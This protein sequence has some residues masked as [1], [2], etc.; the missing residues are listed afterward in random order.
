MK[1]FGRSGGYYIFWTGFLYFCVGLYSMFVE[2]IVPV[3]IAQVCWIAVLSLP[4][5]IPPFGRWLNMDIT[6]DNKLFKSDSTPTNV[7]PF[8]TERNLPEPKLVPPM[9][10]VEPPKVEPKVFYRIGSTDQ[11]RVAFSMGG[12]E[13]TMN[14]VGCQQMID[15][16]TVFMNQLEDEE[17]EE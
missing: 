1:L 10:K 11:H 2:P 16:L 6:W 8:P 7:V 15:Q 12:M 14:K 13:I 5:A 3:A 4:F 9:P 17:T